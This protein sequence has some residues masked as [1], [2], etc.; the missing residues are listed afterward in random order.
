MPLALP[1]SSRDVLDGA[2]GRLLGGQDLLFGAGQPHAPEP[3]HRR[4]VDDLDV[5]TLLGLVGREVDIGGRRDL[6]DE[7]RL[8]DLFDLVDH[9]TRRYLGERY[10]FDGLESTTEEIRSFLSR[11]RPPVVDGDR[12]DKFLSDTDLVKYTAMRPRREDCADVLDRAEII[13]AKTTPAYA[14]D[15]KPSANE[16]AA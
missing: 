14:N 6:D 2:D 16:G 3:A 12:V 8:D 13:V 5:G 10:G 11:V 4:D 1:A 15:T 9:C 7:E